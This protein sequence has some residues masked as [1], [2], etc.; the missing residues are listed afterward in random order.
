MVDASQQVE[1]KTSKTVINP[2]NTLVSS[3]ANQLG[4]EENQ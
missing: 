2:L 3:I 4:L 1:Y